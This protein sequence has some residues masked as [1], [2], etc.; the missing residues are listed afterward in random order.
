MKH[1]HEHYI[2]AAIE[3]AYKNVDSGGRPF[4]SVVVKDGQIV[5]EACNEAHLNNDPTAHAEFLAIKRAGVALGT[6]DLSDCIVYASGQPC[7]FCMATMSV[8]GIRQ[9]Y[10]GY[11]R[12][13]FA[14]VAPPN[15]YPPVTVSVV[16]PDDGAALYHYW[17][18]K[19]G[20]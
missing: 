13:D 16:N 10:Y 18:K 2:H 4:G 6:R 15:E 1:A 14:S 7:P 9:A 17:K 19:H 5:A 8:Y 20:G 12:D 3:L 11:T